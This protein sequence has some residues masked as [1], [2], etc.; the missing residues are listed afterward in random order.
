MRIE[1]RRRKRKIKRRR[2]KRKRREEEE[3]EQRRV[4]EVT[5]KL[6]GRDGKTKRV[7]TGGVGMA[8]ILKIY[9]T[10]FSNI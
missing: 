7:T 2:E 1:G 8:G 5:S 4:E 6:V 9:C 3:E 10:E